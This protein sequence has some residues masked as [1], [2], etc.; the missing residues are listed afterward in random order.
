MIYS[1]T[2]FRPQQ[3]LPSLWQAV[4]Q[5]SEPGTSRERCSQVLETLQLLPLWGCFLRSQFQEQTLE[6]EE[7]QDAQRTSSRGIVT[8]AYGIKS[9][10]YYVIWNNPSVAVRRLFIKLYADICC[11]IYY[12]LMCCS[13]CLI[14]YSLENCGILIRFPKLRQGFL[15]QQNIQVTKAGSRTKSQRGCKISR[16]CIFSKHKVVILQQPAAGG[17][18]QK[19]LCVSRKRSIIAQEYYV[20][21]IKRVVQPAAIRKMRSFGLNCLFYFCIAYFLHFSRGVQIITG[22]QLS[23]GGAN[24]S[25]GVRTPLNPA[26]QVTLF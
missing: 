24:F 5:R 23:Q 12:G 7:M 17:N 14:Y 8:T 6:T 13:N 25:Q 18:F 26:M 16:G 2:Y 4:L 21:M 10:I 15:A 1:S 11:V 20:I 9:Y 22:V 3:I 19:I